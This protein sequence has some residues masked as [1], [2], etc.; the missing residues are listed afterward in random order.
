VILN[1][2]VGSNDSIIFDIYSS[3]GLYV[4]AIIGCVILNLKSNWW[5]SWIFFYF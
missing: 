3:H 4:L 2:S 5:N 1:S